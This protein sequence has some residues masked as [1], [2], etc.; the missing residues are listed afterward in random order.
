MLRLFRT[1][2]GSKLLVAATGAA[3]IG[4]LFV[5]AAGNLLVLKGADA[6]NG[7]ADWLQGHPLLWGFRAGLL[8]LFAVHIGVSIRLAHENRAAR[9]HRYRRIARLGSRLPGRLMPV[10]GGL[11]LAFLVFHLLHLTVRTVGP[12]V[13]PLHDGSGR[14]DVYGL[15]VAGFSE[16][17]IAAVYVA[18]MVLLG[19]HLVH[20]IEALFQTLGFNHDS[21]QP[22]IRVLGP[23]LA[24]LIAGGFASIPLLVLV[25]VIGGG[26]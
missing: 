15:L 22:L 5:H 21:Y 17:W 6:L 4:F 25:G 12:M 2:I 7:Y 14:V 16:P 1:S 8:L 10:S 13:E 23:A 11:L 9:P 19:L 24:L 26:S 20:A 3:L 18:A